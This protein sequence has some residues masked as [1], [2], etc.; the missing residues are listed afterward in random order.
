MTQDIIIPC[1][2][3][4]VIM[5]AAAVFP[6]QN[7]MTGQPEEISLPDRVIVVHGRKKVTLDGTQCR[8]IAECM[9]RDSVFRDW[10]DKC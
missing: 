10:C 9:K 6:G 1:L 4:S 5:A 7:R 3:G 8:F 2:G